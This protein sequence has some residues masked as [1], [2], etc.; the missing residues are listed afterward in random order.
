MTLQRK[1]ICIIIFSVIPPIL[2][3]S[4]FDKNIVSFLSKISPPSIPSK[5]IDIC[6][7][8]A[9]PDSVTDCKPVFDAALKMAAATKGGLRIIIPRG[10]YLKNGL[11]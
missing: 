3:A 4:S 8:G 10:T 9:K 11:S 7:L 2:L 1:N 5:A 6:S